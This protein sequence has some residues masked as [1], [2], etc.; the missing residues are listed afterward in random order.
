MKNFLY[1]TTALIA[2]G[3]VAGGAAAQ[4]AAPAKAAAEPLKLNITGNWQ[5][6]A[7]FGKQSGAYTAS[8]S[9]AATNSQPGAGR[10]NH[11]LVREGEVHFSGQTTLANGMKVGLRVELEAQGVGDTATEGPGAG[12]TTSANVS[13]AGV[14]SNQIDE[15]FG[16]FDAS[17]G[18]LEF[19]ATWG[20]SLKMHYTGYS[21]IPNFGNLQNLGF[22]AGATSTSNVTA[23]STF[24]TPSVK[25]DKVSLYTPRVYGLQFGMSYTPEGSA[26]G[27]QGHNGGFGI[28]D[29]VAQQSQIMEYALNYV[30]K[31]GAVDLAVAGTFAQ[32]R[33]EIARNSA[34][35]ST[36]AQLS[37]DDRQAYGVGLNVKAF[38]VEAGGSWLH[39]NR[40][41]KNPARDRQTWE[42]GVGYTMGPASFGIQYL[43]AK[44]DDL[45]DATANSA[46]MTKHTDKHTMWQVGGTYN[47]GPGID[48]IGGVQWN[49]IENGCR[50]GQT[51]C[52]T[53]AVKQATENK[54]TIVV[55]GTRLR[56]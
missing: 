36:D 39:D 19:G 38:G 2:V 55:F 34:T 33:K 47:L 3:L 30:N 5:M 24:N 15:S 13:A 6:F 18:R 14:N 12:N 52:T 21:P 48:L 40:G 56:F 50:V 41:L 1:G 23:I 35:P 16:F 4:Q 43:E 42:I 54:A 10:R 31:F 11:G 22:I 29:T 25:N 28:D 20:A 44:A 45:N 49:D 37:A 17:W 9:A 53:Q 46:T 27:R 8:P 51:A 7:G 32:S 26:T